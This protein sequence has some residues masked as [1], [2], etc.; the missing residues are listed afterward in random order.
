M[1]TK[2]KLKY[3]VKMNAVYYHKFS[4]WSKGIC[5]ML[6]TLTI[7]TYANYATYHTHNASHALKIFTD[8]G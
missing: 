1:K 2:T 7:L 3:A 5:S 6:E 8:H 4:F